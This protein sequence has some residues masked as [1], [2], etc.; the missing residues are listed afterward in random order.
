MENGIFEKNMM[1]RLTFFNGSTSKDSLDAIAW[2]HEEDNPR[3][4]F[5]KK[6]AVAK[7]IVEE[8]GTCFN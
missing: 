5:I 7:E 4:F 2:S 6:T 8:V 3:G 1:T